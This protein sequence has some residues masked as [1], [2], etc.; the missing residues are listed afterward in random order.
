MIPFPIITCEN[1]NQ[2]QIPRNTNICYFITNE[3]VFLYKNL[4]TIESLT[5]VE[6]ISFLEKMERFAKLKIPVIPV[7]ILATSVVYFKYVYRKCNSEGGLIIHYFPDTQ[8][9]SLH[10]PEQDVSSGGVNWDNKK[11]PIPRGA[12]RIGSIHSHADGS[13]FHSYTDQ[14]DEKSFDGI[15]ITI[16]RI[17]NEFSTIVASVVVNANRFK[18]DDTEISEYLDLKIIPEDDPRLEQYKYSQYNYRGYRGYKGW[19]GYSPCY[20]DYVSQYKDKHNSSDVTKDKSS[21]NKVY[22][23]SNYKYDSDERR[24]ELDIDLASIRFDEEWKTKFSRKYAKYYVWDPIK[25]KLVPKDYTPKSWSKYS[26]YSD[27]NWAKSHYPKKEY[28]TPSVYP[29]N[30]SIVHESSSNS[31][32]LDATETKNDPLLLPAPDES[33]Y[34]NDKCMLEEDEIYPIPEGCNRP[35]CIYRRIAVTA[36]ESG[37]YDDIDDP[38]YF[39]DDYPI[40]MDDIP[41]DDYMCGDYSDYGAY[42]YYDH[43]SESEEDIHKYD[44]KP[45][46][47]GNIVDCDGNIVDIN[48]VEATL[49]IVTDNINKMNEMIEG[50]DF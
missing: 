25:G 12:I 46:D 48:K 50:E 33:Y 3:G 19:Y 42:G 17:D 23:P 28:D 43:H 36:M 18:L 35:N 41:Y 24:F 21:G 44:I 2:I 29:P 26:G 1:A 31:N 10:C 27:S 30:P 34:K 11:E 45:D 13:A 40:G 5:K 38:D 16:G 22:T 15:H 49:D 6:S 4:A 32:Q 47:E 39:D 14:D 8:T 7:E 37:L 20:E 9:Y